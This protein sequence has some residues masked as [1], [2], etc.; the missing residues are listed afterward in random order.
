VGTRM[1]KIITKTVFLYLFVCTNVL[2]GQ[3]KNK[4]D[5]HVKYQFN[6]ITSNID[7]T[8]LDNR[9][10]TELPT[11]LGNLKNNYSFEVGF[12][13]S[14]YSYFIQPGVIYSQMRYSG[15][16]RLQ[17][18]LNYH[19]ATYAL[20]LQCKFNLFPYGKHIINPYLQIN[21][22]YMYSVFKSARNNFYMDISSNN[23]DVSYHIVMD[24]KNDKETFFNPLLGISLGSEI[25]LNNRLFLISEIGAMLKNYPEFDISSPTFLS[26]L[27][28]SIGI[29]YKILI[30]RRFY[31]N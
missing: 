1:I 12:L 10:G 28:F 22:S 20:G 5:F 21:A 30:D 3:I 19:I 18:Q 29:R 6:N 7:Q 17:N 24:Y 23:Y 14:N 26:E 15:N 9:Y 16:R 25:L 27:T 8:Y 31:K 11:V 13:N 4:Y 2:Y